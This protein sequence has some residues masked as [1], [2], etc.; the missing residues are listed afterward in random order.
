[1]SPLRLPPMPTVSEIVKLYNLRARKQLS[2]N[3][4]LDQNMTRKIVRSA[5]KIKDGWVCEV[6]PGP[7]GITRCLLEK[8]P[9]ELVV[10]EKDERFFP[11]LQVRK[12]K[13]MSPFC[14]VDS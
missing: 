2:Q 8:N 14:R 3:F 7:G 11:V 1:M 5:G 4:L 12:R 13:N 9:K 6:G 10:I